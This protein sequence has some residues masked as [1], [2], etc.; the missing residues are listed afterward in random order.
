MVRDVIAQANEDRSGEPL[1]VQVMKGGRRLRAGKN[2]PNEARKRASQQLRLLPEP[3]H[4]L[5]R[6]EKPYRVEISSGLLTT[7]R[8]VRMRIK[9]N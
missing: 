2:S 9:K 1:L 6:V 7:L 8:K 5:T 3:L 4:Q